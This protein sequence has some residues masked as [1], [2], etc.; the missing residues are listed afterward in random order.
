MN[1]INLE[2]ERYARTIEKGKKTV[3]RT[4]KRLKKEGKTSMPLETLIDLYDA[5]GMPPETVEEIGAYAFYNCKKLYSV[6]I[7]TG[8][9]RIEK[10]AV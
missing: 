4:I 9:K 6:A 8:V 1:I 7:G 5:Q 2:E 10:S 3:K